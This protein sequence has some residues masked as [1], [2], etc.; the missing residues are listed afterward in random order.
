[1]RAL[2]L[3]L[4]PASIAEPELPLGRSAANADVLSAKAT[5]AEAKVKFVFVFFILYSP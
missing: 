3:T 4:S 2:Q 5:A 1:M